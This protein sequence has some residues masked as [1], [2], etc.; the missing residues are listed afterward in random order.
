MFDHCEA[1]LSKQYTAMQTMHVAL[2]A[3]FV[4]Q[5]SYIDIVSCHASFNLNHFIPGLFHTDVALWKKPFT[6]ALNELKST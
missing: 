1:N 5:G 6:V 2:A 3:G 4:S